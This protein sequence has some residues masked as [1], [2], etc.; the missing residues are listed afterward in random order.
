M[1]S[2]I[3]LSCTI[4]LC[5]IYPPGTK[6]QSSA[7]LKYAQIM[8]ITY[9]QIVSKLCVYFITSSNT[10]LPKVKSIKD[11]DLCKSDMLAVKKNLERSLNLA[12]FDRSGCTKSLAPKIIIVLDMTFRRNLW[13]PSNA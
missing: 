11:N 13:L 5:F 10:S 4:L 1:E 7:N 3:I 9:S 2:H 8:H 6:S 12:S